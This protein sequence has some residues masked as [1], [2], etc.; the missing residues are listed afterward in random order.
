MNTDKHHTHTGAVILVVSVLI[1]AH[2]GLL[3]LALTGRWSLAVVAGVLGVVVLK[4]AWW[5]LRH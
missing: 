4:Y 3:G 1:A 5:R 2:V